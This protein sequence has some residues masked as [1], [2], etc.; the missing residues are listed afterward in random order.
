MTEAAQETATYED[1]FDS[2]TE[3][4]HEEPLQETQESEATEESEEPD[5][6]ALKLEELKKQNEALQHRIASDDGR[7]SALQRK[8]NE[9]ESA[10]KPQEDL[11]EAIQNPEKWAEVK[12]DYPELADGLETFVKSQI[13]ERL[14]KV[15]EISAKV[16]TFEQKAIQEDRQRELEKLAQVHPDWHEIAQSSE[17]KGWVSAQPEKVRAL[18]DSDDAADAAFLLDTYKA[19]RPKEDA[20]Q[21]QAEKLAAQ[22]KKQLAAAEETPTQRRTP[23]AADESDFEGAFERFARQRE[24]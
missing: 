2:F 22:R 1:D 21:S 11:K 5:E 9:L 12:E 16:G 17:F 14:K 4:A 3:D 13:E 10:Q 20:N 18:A 23:T 8:I 24:R 19:T 15:E 6:Q 7:V